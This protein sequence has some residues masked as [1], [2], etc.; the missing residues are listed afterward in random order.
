M[1]RSV[2]GVS[3]FRSLIELERKLIIRFGEVLLDKL[4]GG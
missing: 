3:E 2:I 1:E 4:D